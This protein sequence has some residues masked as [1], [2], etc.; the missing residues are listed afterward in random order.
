MSTARHQECSC[1]LYTTDR[2]I[3]WNDATRKKTI[4]VSGDVAT[5]WIDVVVRQGRARICVDSDCKELSSTSESYPSVVINYP[6]STKFNVN[7]SNYTIVIES[8]VTTEAEMGTEVELYINYHSFAEVSEDCHGLAC[9]IAP[10]SDIVLKSCTP[11]P[12]P[13]TTATALPPV[14]KE[15]FQQW[16]QGTQQTQPAPAIPSQFPVPTTAPTIVVPLPPPETA[17]PTPAPVE[18]PAPTVTPTVTQQPQ[19]Q[20]IDLNK[21]IPLAV[22]GLIAYSEYRKKRKV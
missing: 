14:S 9:T 12:T 21:I 22:L 19:Q 5:E 20:K 2:W 4:R 1:C 11:T 13:T 10:E 15:E 18:T 17:P 8:F 3:P 7:K 6:G 16:L